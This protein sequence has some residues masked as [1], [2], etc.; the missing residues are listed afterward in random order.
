MIEFYNL[1]LSI[2]E[3]TMEALKSTR[4]QSASSLRSKPTSDGISVLCDKQIIRL[5]AQ[6]TVEQLLIHS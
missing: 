1:L 3:A 4:L 5:Y 2:A 6:S